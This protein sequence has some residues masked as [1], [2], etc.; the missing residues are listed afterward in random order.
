MAVEIVHSV[1]YTATG[2]YQS[3]TPSFPDAQSGDLVVGLAAITNFTGSTSN[4]SVFGL[5]GGLGTFGWNG[6]DSSVYSELLVTDF[7]SFDGVVGFSQTSGQAIE[8]GLLVAVV[9][10][11]TLVYEGAG[12][13][14][15]S[16][17]AA[18]SPVTIY[19]TT[20]YDG[21]LVPF[22]SAMIYGG[23]TG[24]VSDST[25]FLCESN[26]TLSGY[27]YSLSLAL[28]DEYNAAENAG[29]LADINLLHQ[30]GTFG[31]T[32]EW[33]STGYYFRTAAVT[34]TT[35]PTAH[36]TSNVASGTAPLTVTF[37][38]ASS[39]AGDTPIEFY[40]FETGGEIVSATT[41]GSEV[42]YANPG[43]YTATLTVTDE[44]GLTDTDTLTITV[45]SSTVTTTIDPTSEFLDALRY[46]HR[47]YV[48]AV[49]RT[50]DCHTYDLPV[51]D[52]SVTIDRNSKTRRSA[53]L[54]VAID[55]LG[56]DSRDAL[57]RVT[58]QSGE[59]E[60]HTGITYE[61]GTTE[62]ILIARMRID[63]L[64]LEDSASAKIGLYDYALMLDEHPVDPAMG[65][66]IPAGTDWRIA[67]KK[68]IEDTFT[69]TPCGW[70]ELLTVHPD[71]AG[72]EIP[73]QAWD[74][75]NRLS[76][77]LE[78]AEA[79]EC[80]FYNL[81]DGRFHLAPKTDDGEPVWVVDSG[82]YGVLV[83]ATQKFDRENQ[84]N[85]VAISFQVPDGDIESIRAFVVDDDPYSPTRWGG[86]FG[87]KVLTLNNI[88]AA[89]EDEARRIAIRKLNENKGATRALS[90]KT[91][92]NPALLP[93]QVILV[94]HPQI[95]NER[96]V[97]EKVVHQLGRGT[98]DID[99]TM[100]RA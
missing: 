73:D 50:P 77:I 29:A 8:A 21:Q 75:V 61:D 33:F 10:G 22:Q 79:R 49:L 82:D 11:M 91:L 53:D 59:V 31:T 17:G 14:G 6:S 74:N 1:V 9:R 28:G 87:K 34:P 20:A 100:S 35:G 62:E 63:S 69:W 72:W 23:S 12:V 48:R 83:S 32:W 13:S 81:P 41:T 96:Q 90:L 7:D 55:Q 68:L 15:P 57:E 58:V 89:T 16:T 97:I 52:G 30:D 4:F 84:Y 60:I 88:P 92:R 40:A 70:D 80:D 67:I 44:N 38:G 65:A 54:T 94:Q 5:E 18:S 2:D 24:L 51:V 98:S 26:I 78:W 46:S 45:N 43:T 71:V 86:P 76:A 42:L 64:E 36:L 19:G 93:G 66:K 99:C 95:T 27:P 25:T 39:T 85:A 56:T 47:A 37:S 3:W